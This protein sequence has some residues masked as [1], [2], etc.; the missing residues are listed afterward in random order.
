MIALLPLIR[1]CLGC[2]SGFKVSSISVLILNALVF[3]R[4]CSILSKVLL[5]FLSS[6]PKELVRLLSSCL[7][8][9]F[10]TLCKPLITFSLKPS[11]T[12]K[13]STLNCAIVHISPLLS[14]SYVKN[15]FWWVYLF[16]RFHVAHI[17]FDRRLSHIQKREKLPNNID[18]LSPCYRFDRTYLIHPTNSFNA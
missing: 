7:V 10:S 1:G 17:G 3:L 15:N 5:N 8:S 12:I 2:L 18:N 9:T 13:L 11:S 4:R 14:V 16:R 6:C